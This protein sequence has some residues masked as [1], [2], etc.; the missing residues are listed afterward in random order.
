LG[1][2]DS[3]IDIRT[4]SA[5]SQDPETAQVIKR[6]SEFSAFTK[7]PNI[8]KAVGFPEFETDLAPVYEHSGTNISLDYARCATP[9]RALGAG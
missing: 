8:G 3:N 2:L 9:L 4:D 7:T 1:Y 5:P 6:F